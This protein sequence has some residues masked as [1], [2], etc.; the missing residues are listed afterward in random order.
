MA[1]H[2]I[3]CCG[4]AAPSVLVD[5]VLPAADLSLLQVNHCDI[6]SAGINALGLIWW[7]AHHGLL[8]NLSH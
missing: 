7:L 6:V 2:V 4:K 5:V 8:W 1:A 3:A